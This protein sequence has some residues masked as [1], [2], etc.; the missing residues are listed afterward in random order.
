[1][2]DRLLPGCDQLGFKC[3]ASWIYVRHRFH[4]LAGEGSGSF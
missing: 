4:A 1:V 2:I 3:D